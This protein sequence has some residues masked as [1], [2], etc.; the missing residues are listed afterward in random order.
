MKCK[1]CGAE[2]DPNS[3]SCKYCGNSIFANNSQYAAGN[4]RSPLLII[5]LVIIILFVA[6]AGV[7]AYIVYFDTSPV[8]LMQLSSSV[9]G[10]ILANP[11]LAGNMPNSNI[12]SQVLQA[13]KSGVPVYKIGDGKGPV[14]VI[15]SGVHGDQLVPPVAAMKIINY[16]DGRK[17]NGTVYVIPFTSPKALEQNTK[18]TNGVNLNTVADESGTLSNQVVDFAIKNNASAVG[19]FHETGVGKDP[20]KTT[21]MCSQIPTYGSFELANAMSQL[22]LDTTLTYYVA[23]IAYDGAVEDELNLKGTPAVTPLVLVSSHGRVQQSAVEE[24][25]TQMLAL[26]IANGNLNPNDPYMKLAN[27]DLDGFDFS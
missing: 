19:D 24:S 2:I 15:A 14:T 18:L 3:R 27:A 11:E 1:Y 23:G 7:F 6:V 20:G 16:L 13:A 10:D 21:I 4:R 17:I 12:T 25:Y 9:S 5:L 26:L 8:E 22:S